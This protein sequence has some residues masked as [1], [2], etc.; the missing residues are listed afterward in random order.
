MNRCLGI[1][2]LC[3]ALATQAFAQAEGEHPTSVSVFGTF[4]T[5]SKLF[6]NPDAADEL[7]R[8]EFL[9]IDGIVSA[10]IDVRRMIEP[11]RLEFGLSV[12]YLA[13]QDA[14][15]LVPPGSSK[16][17]PVADGYRVVPVE[18][19]AWFPI[20][21]GNESFRVMMGGGGGMYIGTRRYEVAGAEA[22]T[23]DRTIGYGIHI[24]SSLEISITPLVLV[25]TD[26]K[27]RDIQFQT[28][29]AFTS[30]STLFEGRAVTLDTTPFSSRVNIDGMTLDVG[31]AFR[32]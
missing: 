30:G 3:A 28:V 13:R 27:F 32:F 19:S 15:T 24:A 6:R 29:N 5:S 10:G 18:L 16:P 23:V 21:I 1:V 31:L 8:D 25:R 9:P 14:S 4:T 2:V 26:V 17:V 12:E 7:L 11:L 20:P 22:A